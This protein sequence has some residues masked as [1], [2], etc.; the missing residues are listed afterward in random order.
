LGHLYQVAGLGI[1]KDGNINI[2]RAVKW[3]ANT[4]THTH[5]HAA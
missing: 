3:H 5:A 2:I 4:L 1:S